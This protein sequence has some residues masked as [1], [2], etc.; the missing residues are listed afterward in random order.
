MKLESI[1]PR[2]R[3]GNANCLGRTTAWIMAAGMVFAL[4]MFGLPAATGAAE[5]FATND[6]SAVDAIFT[7]HCLECHEAK[8]PEANLVLESFESLMK[9][10]EN[11][12]VIVPGN[13]TE[14]LVI[15]MIEGR[16]EKEGKKKIMP[17]GKRAKLDPDEI[18]L[19][20]GWIDAGAKPPAEN[21]VRELAVPKIMPKVPPRR[22]I[23]A[24]AYAPGSKLLAVARYG[25]VE[26]HSAESHA[27]VRTLT[28]HRGN[29]NALVFSTDGQ[30]L[31]AAAGE[32]GLFGEVRQW[33]VADGK[34]IH[35]FEGHR[36]ALYSIAVSPDGATLAT[37]SYDQEIKLW[38]ITTVREVQPLS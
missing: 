34:L 15:K 14:S 10:S 30:Q 23:N 32:A 26:L 9:G 3:G 37:G 1:I 21:K 36:D 8:D 17:P 24:L 19:I 12:A 33:N 20:R 13:S 6:Y 18:A 2:K 22:A 29:V 25:E 7:K 38:N 11:G 27:V 31:F 4:C 35:I 16:V 5:T 28:G